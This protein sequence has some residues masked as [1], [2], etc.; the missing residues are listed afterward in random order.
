MA[1]PVSRF[2]PCLFAPSIFALLW[3]QKMKKTR[4]WMA[5]TAPFVAAP[6]LVILAASYVYSEFS[7]FDEALAALL[8]S[9]A[10]LAWVPH[11]AVSVYLMF[12][13]TTQYNLGNF[14][15]SSKKEWARQ[16]SRDPGGARG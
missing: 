12:R 11:A 3:T 5:A 16:R 8:A 4:R 10:A 9:V 14:G 13:W 15:A 6:Y 2:W 7:S 1:E